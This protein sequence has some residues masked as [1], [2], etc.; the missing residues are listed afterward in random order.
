MT[1]RSHYGGRLL[2]QPMQVGHFAH[3]CRLYSNDVG[4]TEREGGREG[5]GQ[6]EN[7]AEEEK[8]GG[9]GRL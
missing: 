8:E 5:E 6:M 1:I 9:V 3:Y 2:P 7:E 4:C